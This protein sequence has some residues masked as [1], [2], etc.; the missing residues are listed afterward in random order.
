MES[1]NLQDMSTHP[2][3]VNLEDRSRL[4]AEEYVKTRNMGLA[5]RRAFD[6]PSFMSS[7]ELWRKAQGVAE[8][9][10]V[11]AYIE[12][13]SAQAISITSLSAQDMIQDLIDIVAA[14]PNELISYRRH[15][16]RHCNGERGAYQ[17]RDEMEYMREVEV[18]QAADLPIPL[19]D[20]GF[21]YRDGM[22]I[23]EDCDRCGG[24]GVG[25]YHIADTTKLSRQ[26]QLLYRGL[27]VT[28][29]GIEVLMADQGQARRDLMTII[30]L[31]RQDGWK[32]PPAPGD[33]DRGAAGVG[34]STDPVV[35]GKRYLEFINGK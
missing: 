7:A 29:G 13:L 33:V 9:G 17:W 6:P 34:E 25:D 3:A 28:K 31:L 20:G 14:D 21:G 35:V 16:C 23:R 8:R 4:F 11:K 32:P 24:K 1:A 30:G 5:Y 26:G 27:K 10:P 19:C 18:A 2:L 15:G 12:Y 22:P